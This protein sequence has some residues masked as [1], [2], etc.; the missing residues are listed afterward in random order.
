[1]TSNKEPSSILKLFATFDQRWLYLFLFLVIIFPLLRPIGMPLSIG[2]DTQKYYEVVSE[3][4]PEDVVIFNVGLYFSSYMELQ[5]GV[6]ATLRM[7][8]SQGV[9][10]GFTTYW[11]E[12]ESVIRIYIEPA[13]AEMGYKYGKDYIVLGYILPNEASYASLAGDF[14]ATVRKDWVGNP[15]AGTFLGNIKTGADL[16]MWLSFADGGDTFATYHFVQ[17]Y[18]TPQV[19]NVIGVSMTDVKAMYNAGRIKA[20]LGSTRGGAELEKLIGAPGVGLAA[21]DAFT[22]GHYLLIIAIIIGNIGY[23]GYTKRVK[24][25]ERTAIK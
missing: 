10:I 5:S 23:F 13:L 24:G 3:L 9:K 7:L 19:I 4:G 21:M 16:S 18:G 22:L 1:M 15:L 25:Q 8:T 14:Q 6:L 11:P 20:M 12:G 2:A 17:K